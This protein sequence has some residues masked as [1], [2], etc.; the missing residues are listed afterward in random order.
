M[1]GSAHDARILRESA[2]FDAFEEA[3][4][5]PLTGHLLGD[6]GYMC[7]YVSVEY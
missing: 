6:G 3:D 2:V 4:P 5:P 7:R 1:P